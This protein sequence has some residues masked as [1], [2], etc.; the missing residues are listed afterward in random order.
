M[1]AKINVA[2]DVTRTYFQLIADDAVLASARRSVDLSRDNAALT[3]SKRDAGSASELDVQRAKGDVARAEQDVATAALQVATARRSLET[4]S[5]LTPETSTSLPSD[6]LR[7]EPPLEGWLDAT[8]R[9]PTIA[10]AVAAQH[11]ADRSA[12]AAGAAWLPTITASAQERFTN[13]PSLTLH[14]EYYL[15]QATATWKLD[16]TVPAAARAQ[17]AAATVAAARADKTRRDAEDAIFVDWHQ[18]RASIDRAR[19]ARAQIEASARAAQLAHDRYLGG[20]ATQLDVLQAQQDLFRADV[21]R[22]QAEA[23]LAYARASLRLDSGHPI[24]DTRR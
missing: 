8:D 22:I 5:G 23:D 9:I 19:A 13:A 4:L 10:S 7:E 2:R 14:K 18:V 12:S 6:D 11:S 1:S 17:D 20:I 21:A 3:V 24:G 15:L 16:A